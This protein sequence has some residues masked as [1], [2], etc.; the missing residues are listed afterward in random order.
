[1]NAN[2]CNRM[3]IA[4]L[5][6]AFVATSV[7]AQGAMPGMP[8]P[9]QG[10]VAPPDA[11]S[12]DYS[13]GVNAGAMA[14]M[15]MLDDKALGMLLLD[16]L[17]YFDGRDANGV[18]LEAQ[19]WYG[20]DANK[21]WLKVE[22]ERSGGRL[23]NV[24]TEALWDRPL[25]AYWDTQLGVRNDFGV[26]PDRTWAAFGVHGLA[27]Y[28]FEVD[29][30]FYIGQAGRTALRFESTYELRWTQ[31]V[32]L[33]PRFET[34]FYGRNDPRRRIGS[35]LSDAA[36][37]LRLRYEFTRQFAPYVGVEWERRFGRTADL[38]RSAGEAVF[39]PRLVAGFRI[40]F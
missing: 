18:A 10:G 26:G 19:A 20:N 25:A 6:A 32:I 24:R 31:R 28:W 30:A 8:M 35:G 12:P 34:N 2:W 22:G 5:C 3:R 9:M 1:M 16:R 40:W 14:G 39:D 7:C 13:D 21:L 27:P 33:E 17:E 15:D 38:A 36:L 23:Q 29:A 37:G 4:M 11:R